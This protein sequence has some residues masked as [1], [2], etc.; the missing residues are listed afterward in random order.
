MC[1]ESFLVGVI[2]SYVEHE[3]GVMDAFREAFA[4]KTEKAAALFFR[5]AASLGF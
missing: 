3:K 2:V 5:T 4:R 1:W